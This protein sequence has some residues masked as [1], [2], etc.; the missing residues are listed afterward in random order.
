MNSRFLLF[1]AALLL[2][3]TTA[4][5]TTT[6]SSLPYYTE[7]TFTPQWIE[8]P[9]EELH[10]IPPFSFTNQAG[11]AITR[12]SMAGSIYVAN[13]FFT[14]CP[15]ICPDM[16]ENLRQ[17]QNEFSEN[18]D[19]KI[20]SHSVAPTMDTREVLQ[21]YA[22]Q[23]QVE[24]SKWHLLTGSK[25]DI[26]A[27]ARQSYFADKAQGYNKG[28]A[29][30]LHTE[31]FVLIDRTGHIRGVYNGVRKLDMQRLI[32]DIRVLLKE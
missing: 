4:W 30:F 19:V 31:N 13:F 9:T 20:L 1:L 11:E 32:T 14:A 23:N 12:D 8:T 10:R 24:A 16:A 3:C 18:P 22:D 7:A 2:L 28:T 21:R 17:I 26:Y 6:G 25:D 15:G 27:I 5:S 29:E